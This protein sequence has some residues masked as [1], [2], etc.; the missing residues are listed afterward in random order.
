MT[1]LTG[2]WFEGNRAI[3]EELVARNFGFT[4]IA[5]FEL[6]ETCLHGDITAFVFGAMCRKL[7][8]RFEDRSV[9]DW[10]EETMHAGS[11]REAYE[12]YADGA[13]PENKQRLSHAL[14]MARRAIH[15]EQDWLTAWAWES[16][17]FIGWTEDEARDYCRRIVD[18][19]FIQPVMAETPRINRQ[20]PIPTGD[21]YVYSEMK[22]LIGEMNAA[23]WQIWI[24]SMSPRWLAEVVA[25]KF[26]IPGNRVLGMTRALGPQGTI[27]PAQVQPFCYDIGK[28]YSYRNFV[29]RTQ[30]P[31]F[32]AFN[33]ENDWLFA[34]HATD[35][36]LV[37]NPGSAPLRDYAG[38]RA[39]CGE[40]WLIQEF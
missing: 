38:W 36:R 34:E 6:S 30:A 16:G 15:T 19:E 37:I 27:L 3:L 12:L 18:N 21:V 29:N 4:P 31:Q 8:F 32:V 5:V 2:R 10:L 23:H 39:E 26:S 33:E 7:A 40:K 28:W 13:T 35:V 11:I 17:A 20:A 25:E 24:L 9:W 14:E 1:R 22:E